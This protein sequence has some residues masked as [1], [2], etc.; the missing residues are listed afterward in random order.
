MK[1]TIYNCEGLAST[2]DRKAAE[3]LWKKFQEDVENLFDKQFR[4][5]GGNH[6]VELMLL[7]RYVELLDIGF[8]DNDAAQTAQ[9][10]YLS[11]IENDMAVEDTEEAYRHA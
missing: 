10:E 7:N 11:Q 4:A 2:Q 9:D 1:P 5:V 8:E 3:K 6:V